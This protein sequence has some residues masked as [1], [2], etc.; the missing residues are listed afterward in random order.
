M[1]S[2]RLARPAYRRD[3]LVLCI[4]V[5]VIGVTFGVLAD[6]AGFNLPRII[7]L[8]ALVFTGASQFAAVGVIDTGGSGPA[9]VGSALL[10]AGRNTLYGPVVARFFPRRTIAKLAAAHFV[11][12]ETTALSSVQADDRDAAGA[13]WFTGIVL[14][15]FWNGGTIAGVLLGATLGDPQTWGL[16]AAFPASFVALLAPHVK[17]RPG[18]TAAFGGAALA[19]ATVPLTPA[20][21]PLLVAAIA[22]VPAVI[23]R[24]RTG[25]KA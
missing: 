11:I 5:G 12:D 7:V 3:A 8:S 25:G 10:I 9:A 4:A 23:V 17:S 13:F 6:A 24:L 16:D 22:V 19:T 20:G 18:Q 2:G 21:I 14:W 15:L 1:T